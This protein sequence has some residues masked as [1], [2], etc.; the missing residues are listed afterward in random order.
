ML[1]A[2]TTAHALIPGVD[3]LLDVDRQY[4]QSGRHLLH[5]TRGVRSYSV[6]HSPSALAR[7]MRQSDDWVIIDQE[8]PGPNPR[9]TVVTEWRGP[10]KGKRVVRGREEECFEFYHSARG[11]RHSTRVG[12]TM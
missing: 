10:M 11:R 5:T 2:D 4:R 8:V 9:W 7:R 6:L 1:L 3:E 12:V